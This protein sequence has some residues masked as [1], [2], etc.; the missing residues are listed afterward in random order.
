MDRDLIIR[1]IRAALR[2][3]LVFESPTRGAVCLE[4]LAYRLPSS[5]V[6]RGLSSGE[7]AFAIMRKTVAH[8]HRIEVGDPY[9]TGALV[10]FSRHVTEGDDRWDFEVE[11]EVDRT[12]HVAISDVRVVRPGED[13]AD[14]DDPEAE[15]PTPRAPLTDADLLAE[16]MIACPCCGHATLTNRGMYQIC[17][18]CFWEDDGQDTT[19]ADVERGGPNAVSLAAARANF[20]AFGA[21]VEA[22]RA[23]VR[24][25]TREEVRLRQFGPDGRE[26]AV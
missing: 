13:V 23:H 6:V 5:E 1:T 21:S 14:P 9:G 17:P 26:V 2:E 11:V 20:L 16:G 12:G 25:P 18:V 8:P 24:R 19:D 10:V 4:R 7:V 15:P 3:G 22:D